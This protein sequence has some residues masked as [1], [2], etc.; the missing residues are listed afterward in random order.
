MNIN[1]ANEINLST[2]DVT[3][4]KIANELSKHVKAKV[5]YTRLFR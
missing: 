3:N 4:R 2:N 1:L 5:G